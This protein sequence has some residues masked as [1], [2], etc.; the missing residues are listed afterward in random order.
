MRVTEKGQV[1][2]PKDLR[3]AVA[4]Y[5]IQVGTYQAV[6][7]S[8]GIGGRQTALEEDAADS[9]LESVWPD[10]REAFGRVFQSPIIVASVA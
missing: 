4:G 3:D 6:G 2:I 8:G 1:T 10:P 9:V 7:S 5:A